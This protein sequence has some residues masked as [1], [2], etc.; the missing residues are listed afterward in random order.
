MSIV[1]RK[2]KDFPDEIL[3]RDFVGKVN[4]DEIID[5]WD[6]LLQNG[7]LDN[8]LRGVVNVLDGCDLEMNMNTFEKL[9]GYLKAH[10]VF[11]TIKLAVVCDC[12]QNIVFPS[13]GEYL[14][15]DLSIKPF[16]SLTFAV[17]W[18]NE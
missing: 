6:D 12:P 4:V 9:M 3:I 7:K 18:I 8:K 13:M 1:Y 10:S 2:H 16:S 15:K 11:K 17:N 5:S 14:M